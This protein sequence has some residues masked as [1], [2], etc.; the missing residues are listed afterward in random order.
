MYALRSRHNGQD[1][2]IALGNVVVTKELYRTDEA[3]ARRE[4]W[5][6][7]KHA[8][9]VDVLRATSRRSGNN[10]RR[11]HQIYFIMLE[12]TVHGERGCQRLVGT[13]GD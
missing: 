3:V 9:R 6:H 4:D 12:A 11:P 2:D 5:V 1:D 8:P 10:K 13:A 7:E